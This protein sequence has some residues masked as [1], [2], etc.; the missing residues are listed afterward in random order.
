MN[1]SAPLLALLLA[2]LLVSGCGPI[3][4]IGAKGPPAES[5]LLVEATARPRPVP[6]AS[7]QTV[8]VDLPQLPAMLQTLRLAVRISESEIK[9]LSA[10]SWAETPSRQVQRLLADTL[11]SRGLAVL[12]RSQASA[13]PDATLSGTLRDFSLDVRDPG[14]P[15]VRVRYDAQLSRPGDPRPIGLRRFEASEP[16]LDQTPAAVAAA[17]ARASNALAADLADWTATTLN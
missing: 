9:Y 17:L 14:H 5:L 16:A 7:S 3:V 6:N 8:A 13:R 2:Q 15:M 11:A 10:A 4:Q 1:R 12:D